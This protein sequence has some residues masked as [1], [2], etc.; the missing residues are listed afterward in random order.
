LNKAK[1][2]AT[3][4]L[5]KNIK[6]F[7][8]RYLAAEGFARIRPWDFEKSLNGLTQGVGFVK[9]TGHLS[10]MFTVDIYWR[11]SHS[12]LKNSPPSARDCSRRIGEFSSGTDEWYPIEDEQS[13]VRIAEVFAQAAEPFLK[14]HES[15]EAILRDYEERRCPPKMLFGPDI[16]WMHFNIGFCY[17][18]VGNK[19]KAAE[20]LREVVD[21][22]SVDPYDWV[23]HRKDVAAEGLAHATQTE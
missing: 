20:H 11:F 10:G 6:H 12:Q 1:S 18:A 13:Y 9:G 15:I 3:K 23:Q 19:A 22:L 17:L 16:G 4:E 2:M 14:A 21:K 7:G 5:K 8:E